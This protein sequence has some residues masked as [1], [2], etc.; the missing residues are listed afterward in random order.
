MSTPY[1]GQLMLA[2]FNFPPNGWALCNGQLMP[3]SQNQALFSLLGTTFGGNGIQTFALP[4]LQGATPVGVGNGIAAGEV[5]GEAFHT[6]TAAEVPLHT[7]VLNSV[8]PA[9][10]GKLAFTGGVF[11][12][13]SG[14][15]DFAPASNLVALN[16]GTLSPAGGSQPHENRQP[17]LVM[18][19]C[20]ALQGIYPT[21]N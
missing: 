15:N 11:L 10:S 5:G 2:S 7:H 6:L 19:W 20:I 12:A 21:Q 17:F 3:I 18:S 8:S 9:T 14:A 1:M 16:S 4:N 13:G